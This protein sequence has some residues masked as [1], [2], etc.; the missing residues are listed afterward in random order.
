M[1]FQEVLNNVFLLVV[2]LVCHF[3]VTPRQD[4]V[5]PCQD[6]IQVGDNLKWDH[7]FTANGLLITDTTD[8]IATAQ[9]THMG[10]VYTITANAQVM[11]SI[12]HNT[13]K[14]EKFVQLLFSSDLL[15]KGKIHYSLVYTTNFNKFLIK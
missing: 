2:M 3:A 14:K 10:K 6:T 7:L 9:L 11:G 4:M 8:G 5:T 1:S 15:S 12:Y 13:H